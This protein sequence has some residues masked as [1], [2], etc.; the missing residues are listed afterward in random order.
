M[1]NYARWL[2]KEQ[3]WIGQMEQETKSSLVKYCAL[4][5]VGC[6]VVFGAIGLL[7]N[8]QIS[9]MLHNVIFGLIFGLVV[10]VI[11][12]IYILLTLPAKPY[13]KKL[14]KETEENLTPAEREKLASQM[15][16]SDVRCVNYRDSDKTKERVLV[17]KDFLLSSSA[18]AGFMLVKL[19]QI[20]RL[21]TDV[22][23]ITTTTRTNSAKI[24]ITNQVF[25]I[26]FHYKQ[27]EGTKTNGADAVCAFPAREI[28][29]QVLQYMREMAAL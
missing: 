28:R 12:A 4:C 10:S 3:E 18:R 20:E 23:D 22:R 29:D 15:L 1:D 14:R 26:G 11:V 25:V 5:V 9:D 8:G 19:D 7:A 16:S 17:T 6:V 2:E 24:A 13:M 21:E 27:M